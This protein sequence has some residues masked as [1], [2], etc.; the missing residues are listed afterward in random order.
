MNWQQDFYLR[1][2]KIHESELQNYGQ[3]GG[4]NW[5]NVGLTGIWPYKVH[6]YFTLSTA[7]SN[8]SGTT[9]Q[10]ATSIDN[11]VMLASKVHLGL[12]IHPLIPILEI[13]AK[14]L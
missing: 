2:K 9:S 11:E 4:A 10:L 6:T 13:L 7:T 12:D 1:I 14:G 3:R 8:H 5:R